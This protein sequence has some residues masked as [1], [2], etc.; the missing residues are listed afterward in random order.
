VQIATID[1]NLV[2]I[3]LMM[4]K[5]LS[6]AGFRHSPVPVCLLSLITILFCACSAADKKSVGLFSPPPYQ[7]SSKEMVA[8][9]S[10]SAMEALSRGVAAVT[11]P[12]AALHFEA[13]RRPALW[14]HPRRAAA[15]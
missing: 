2:W 15:S 7:N 4:K 11:P 3:C 5:W 12:G 6:V 10:V 8:A 9:R 13:P 1:Q 14:E